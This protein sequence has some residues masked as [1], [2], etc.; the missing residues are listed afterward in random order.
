MI[1]LLTRYR[2]EWMTIALERGKK[3]YTWASLLAM[4]EPKMEGVTHASA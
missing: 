3:G 1:D 4:H 2:D